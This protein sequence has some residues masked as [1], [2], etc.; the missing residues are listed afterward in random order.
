MNR[1]GAS[2]T[3]IAKLGEFGLID[4][5]L[6]GMEPKQK[7]TILGPGDD[8]AVCDIK[9]RQLIST[10]SMVEGIHF[11]LSYSPLK[12]LGYKAV[13]SA[14]S[15]IYAMN[16]K[17]TGVLISLAIGSRYTVEA[18]E[19]IYRGIHKAC[20]YYEVDVLGGDTTSSRAGLMIN[21][22]A[23]GEAKEDQIVYR[24]GAQEGD[25]ICV[26]GTLGSAYLGLQVLEREKA[27]YAADPNMQP[28]LDEYQV[29][30]ERQLK[31]EA[32]KD[33]I[34]ELSKLGVIPTSMIDVSDGLSSELM[35]ICRQSEVGCLIYEENIPIHEQAMTVAMD[36]FKISPVTCALS[37]GEDYELLF[38]V[39]KKQKDLIRSIPNVSIIG[40]IR[41][42]SEGRKL[43]SPKGEQH[44][45]VAQG[46]QHLSE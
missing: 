11:D 22:T 6:L 32:R 30:V 42:T 26:S 10:D 20:L 46:W 38:S 37:G 18:I 17:P 1:P 2:L 40:E 5:I 12:H 7:T 28:A 8:A 33:I 21:V 24:K 23:I 35:H 25:L 45:L 36:E 15:D 27:V 13:S 43:M 29:L 4:R 19:E 14:L 39:N 16:G 31:P 9:L 44:E 3:P 41:P 34:E